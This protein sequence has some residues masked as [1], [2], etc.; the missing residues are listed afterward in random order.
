[1]T[2]STTDLDIPAG[3]DR[4]IVSA[5]LEMMSAERGA[6][7]NTLAA[8]GRDLAAYAS[9]LKARGTD[10][11]RADSGDIEAFLA[12]LARQGLARTSMARKLSAV[13][14]L[15]KF[16][17]GESLTEADPSAPV[18]GPRRPRG[19]PKVLG[20]AEVGRLVDQARAEAAAARGAARLKALR[21]HC[22]MEL[23]YATGL[24]VSE[25]A[26][27]T[28]QAATADAR[29]ILVRGKGG[30][31]RLVPLSRP[32]KAALAAYLAARARAEGGRAGSAWLF[33]SRAGGG[34]LT[35][36]HIGLELKGL[37]A[38]AG[39]DPARV[40]PHVLRHAFASHLLQGGADLRAVQQL[41]GHA[42]ISTTQIYTHVLDE[43]LREVVER[44][45]PLAGR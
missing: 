43:R 4:R 27:L 6:A 29:F 38:R 45:H 40:S 21:L 42:D 24:R 19:L 22:L 14:Q 39:L 7:A 15:H 28:V 32:A 30:K 23:A 13:R 37:A 41:L 34:H 9:H 5:F 44:H 3:P 18:V 1:M 8:Y 2:G 33:A 12:G 31:E 20:A 10:L 11:A 17:C 16:A 25:L 26:G 35:R 36:Q